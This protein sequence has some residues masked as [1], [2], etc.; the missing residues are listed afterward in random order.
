MRLDGKGNYSVLFPTD[1]TE[2]LFSRSLGVYET[3]FS[4]SFL[5]V[6]KSCI[7]NLNFLRT[8]IDEKHKTPLADGYAGCLFTAALGGS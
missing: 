3:I 6:H 7:I 4:K 1:G 8:M 5:R 2:F